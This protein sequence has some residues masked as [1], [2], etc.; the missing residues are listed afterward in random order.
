MRKLYFIFI[1]IFLLFIPCVLFAQDDGTPCGTYSSSAIVAA[2]NTQGYWALDDMV[3]QFGLNNLAG[4]APLIYIFVIIGGLIMVAMG[5]PPKNYI[6]W[7]F[8]PVLFNFLLYTPHDQG[9]KGVAWKI[10][11]GDANSEDQRK[12]W[13]FAEV[14]L[15]NQ[16]RGMDTDVTYHNDREP[17]QN[18][19]NLPW[20]FLNFDWVLSEQ[21]GFLV[22]WA[23]I[24]NQE[25]NDGIDVIKPDDRAPKTTW[26]LMSNLKWP[27]LEDITGATLANADIKEGLSRFLT[28]E[29]GTII[30]EY[31]KKSNF[32][33]A[34]SSRG[35]K[36]PAFVLKDKEDNK[37][38]L[39]KALE[40][41]WIPY[42]E[43]IRRLLKDEQFSRFGPV[44]TFTGS[45]NSNSQYM[46]CMQFIYIIVQAFRWESGFI[47]NNAV[48]RA[49]IPARYVVYSFLYGWDFGDKK[50]KTHE[51]IKF[52]Q[53][54]IL[55]HLFRNELFK[56][57]F[58]VDRQFSASERSENYVKAN[59]GQVG[60]KNKYGELYMWA[61]L[62]P[63]IQGVTLYFLCG[64]YP[65][66]CLLMIIPG[67][68]KA[69]ISWMLFYAWAR[70]WDAG[71]AVVESL[72]RNIWGM[73]GSSKDSATRNNM[74]D[75]MR[76]WAEIKVTGERCGP[77]SNSILAV[78]D[79]KDLVDC[80]EVLVESVSGDNSL[81]SLQIF[82]RS[83]LMQFRL[84][85][86]VMNAYYVYLMSALFFAVPV[87]TGQLILAAKAGMAN[88]LTQGISSSAS[89]A[90][91]AAGQG[92]IGDVATQSSN[93][94]AVAAQ[95][96]FARGL[97]EERKFSDGKVESFASRIITS[98]NESHKQTMMA[99]S[100]DAQSK[101]ISAIGGQAET[102]LGSNKALIHNMVA[103]GL[104]LFSAGKGGL[105]ALKG[106]AGKAGNFFTNGGLPGV[107]KSADAAID[108]QYIIQ[109]TK[110]GMNTALA[111]ARFDKLGAIAGAE[112]T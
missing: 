3:T 54:M 102:I 112:A 96:A 46:N 67:W 89:Q 35:S 42:P 82:D 111:G 106:V 93:M 25:D 63:Y 56:T 44:T 53:N 31:I 72:E 27:M 71:F 75:E 14:G 79:E 74:I 48:A 10:G 57:Y 77:G 84:D 69:F 92:Y 50:L 62:M 34:S 60:S 47:Y 11:T 55:V 18:T 87:V 65:F 66:A 85:F 64:A 4:W 5:M 49:Q 104:G 73:L 90:G 94:R 2:F 110:I 105:D 37:D 100:F 19:T 9:C 8:G 45:V 38:N 91:S 28:S 15:V 12:V 86:D 99:S 41:R 22:D 83:I 1:F 40:Q 43:E 52:I 51:Q 32:I 36:L 59:A 30:G 23:G 21:V 6:W 103:G 78:T 107:G 108:S 98:Q 61:K 95:E 101:Q 33:S 17:D 20:F 109:E 97:R 26:S 13:Q 24:G 88:T 16:N 7:V 76:T 70:S 29:C 58:P 39:I 80:R 81:S 68:H